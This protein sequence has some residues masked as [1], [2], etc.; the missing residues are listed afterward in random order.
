MR[1]LTFTTIFPNRSY[2]N[3]GVFVRERTH[4]LAKRCGVEVVA[5]VPRSIPLPGIARS[6]LLASVPAREE[7]AGLTVHHPRYLSLPGSWARIKPR[8]IARGCW[9]TVQRLHAEQPFDLID[10]HFA[11]PDGAAAARLAR[12]LDIPFV[13]SLRGSDIHRDMDRKAIR[14]RILETTQHAAALIAVARPLADRLIE[15]GVDA[16]KIH[17]IP[18]G[19]NADR[20]APGDRAAARAAIGA[21]D[22]RPLL[23]AVG[24]LRWIKGFDLLIEAMGEVPSD[25]ALWIVGEGEMRADLKEQAARAGLSNRIRF[26]GAVAHEELPSYYA[27]ADG[28]ILP[29]RNEGCPNVLLEALASGCPTIATSVGH[30]PAIIRNG[31][32]G[33][34]VAPGNASALAAAMRNLLDAHHDRARIRASVTDLTWER[35]AEQ[36]HDVFTSLRGSTNPASKRTSA[37][38]AE[39]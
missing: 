7:I 19:V 21:D 4:H 37:C 18:N 5:P 36:V 25:V 39:F 16:K 35:V 24:A 38:S 14:P 3:Q 33:Q 29:S 20:F 31:E 6:N 34:L 30:V 15:A 2:P 10:A 28:F 1:V 32:N 23:L 17:V 11:H 9:P 12:R 26:A 22:D 27:A 8:S 13:L